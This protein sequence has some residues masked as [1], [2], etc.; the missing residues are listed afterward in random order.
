MSAPPPESFSLSVG[1]HVLACRAWPARREGPPLLALHGFTGTGLDAAPL[2]EA[3]GLACWAPDLLGHARSAAPRAR[4]PY[5]F[6]AQV[7]QV[8]ALPEALGLDRPLLFAYSFG[9]R[10]AL[11]AL[12]AR[13]EAFAGAVLVGAT[14]GIED[15]AARAARAAE[16]EAR[17]A[18]IEAEGA[19]AFLRAWRR[20]PLIRTQERIDPAH[21]ARRDRERA[22]HTAHG[23]AHALREAGTGRMPPLWGELRRVSCP[24][25]ALA[26]AEDPKFAALAARLARALPAGEHDLV[27]GAGHCAHLE[28]PAEAVSRIDAFVA[29]LA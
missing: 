10:L 17:A 6:A 28:A 5:A 11:G 29:R 14:A 9:A 19:A 2:A 13:G 3:L 23:L 8:C 15:P 25:L 24:V 16:D 20:H 26:G 1:D 21:R 18:R 27:R 4:G 22:L 12:V 7:A